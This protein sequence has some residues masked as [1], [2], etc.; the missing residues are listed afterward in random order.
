M[1]G[2]AKKMT[3][4]KQNAQN[5]VSLATIFLQ[6]VSKM[7]CWLVFHSRH[8]YRRNDRRFATFV[9]SMQTHNHC[10]QFCI[11][12]Q[13]GHTC[14]CID[15]EA[16]ALFHLSPV[17]RRTASS[18]QLVLTMN[19]NSHITVDFFTFNLAKFSSLSLFSGLT[20]CIFCV[21]VLKMLGHAWLNEYAL[22]N[23]SRLR[24][25]A[26]AVFFIFTSSL[27]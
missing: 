13:I 23:E 20:E 4:T 1:S 5:C 8:I 27:S 11:D 14:L 9:K 21:C 24:F 16:Q 26:Y 3:L 12:R 15:G 22:D 2:I 18:N 7:N 6:H 19:H 10:H 17:A 25:A